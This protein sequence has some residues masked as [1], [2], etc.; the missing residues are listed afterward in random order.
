MSAPSP[1]SYYPPYRSRSIFGPLLLITVGVLWLLPSMRVVSLHSL[2]Q[3]FGHWFPVLLI[4]LGV[5]RLLEHMWARQ[6]G[7][8]TPRMGAGPVVFL[9]F[10]T[11]FGLIARGVSNV[12]WGGIRSEIAAEN[13]DLGDFLNWGE[14]YEY[15]ENFA[16]PLKPASQIKILGM[17]GNIRITASPDDQAHAVLQ[18]KIRGDSKE[19]ADRA[20]EA[21]HPKFEQRAGVL[22]LDLTGS[23]YQRGRFDLDLQLPRQAGLSVSTRVGD[24]SIEQRDASI[25]AATDRGDVSLEQIKG[26]ATIRARGRSS[27]T[28]RNIT[29]NV[30]IEGTIN[31]TN[32]S[33]VGGTLTTSGTYLGTMQLARIAR[34]VRFSSTRTDLQFARLNGEMTMEIDDLRANDVAGP[35]RITTKSKSIHLDQVSGDVQINNRNASVEVTPKQPMGAMDITN[36]HGEIDLTLPARA[37]FQLDAESLGGEVQTDF[38]LTVDNAHNASVAKGTVGKGGP[39]VRLKADHG[40]IQIRKQ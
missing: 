9:V 11:I 7:Q 33:D 14:S 1:V 13:P 39:D 15:G 21:T 25:E 28:A 40:T 3:W 26:D 19:N 4:V 6:Q 36:F 35:F 22:L 34:Q 31:D 2:V 32:I 16:A 24:I 30:S 18:K 17:R 38:G 12:N 37:A 8:P 27:I 5:A 10:F 23:D 29:G 20:N